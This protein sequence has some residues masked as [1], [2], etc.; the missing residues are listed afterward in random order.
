MTAFI[1][2]DLYNL[3]EYLPKSYSPEECSELVG[4]SANETSHSTSVEESREILGILRHRAGSQKFMTVPEEDESQGGGSGGSSGD[5]AGREEG[6]REGR[7]GPLDWSEFLQ[8]VTDSDTNDTTDTKTDTTTNSANTCSPSSSNASSPKF[9]KKIVKS[10]GGEGGRGSNGDWEEHRKL[11]GGSGARTEDETEESMDLLEFLSKPRSNPEISTQSRYL[12]GDSDRDRTRSKTSSEKESKIITGLRPSRSGSDSGRRNTTSGSGKKSV[13]EKNYFVPPRTI[14][15]DSPGRP[16]EEDR[17][18]E[19]ESLDFLEFLLKE[20][21]RENSKDLK[22]SGKKNKPCTHRISGGSP[23]QNFSDDEDQ[24]HPQREE[25]E[26]P[27]KHVLRLPK[28]IKTQTSIFETG[29]LSARSRSGSITSKNSEDSLVQIPKRGERKKSREKSAD[30]HHKDRK[31]KI[32]PG[33]DAE[34][35]SPV[36]REKE[37]GKEKEK[38]KDKE[39]EKRR[40]KDKEKRGREKRVPDLANSS[41]VLGASLPESTPRRSKRPSASSDPPEPLS[42]ILSHTK[43]SSSEDPPRNPSEPTLR[44]SKRISADFN[45]STPETPRKIKRSNSNTKP[46]DMVPPSSSRTSIFRTGEPPSTQTKPP[47]PFKYPLPSLD[48]TS[49]SST[50]TMASTSTTSIP[51]TASDSGTDAVSTRGTPPN[52]TRIGTPPNTA[53]TGTGRTGT[54]PNTGRTGTP[55]NSARTGTPPNSGRTGTPPNTG[56]VGTPPNTGRAGTPPK[57]VTPTRRT[58]APVS[59]TPSIVITEM[60]DGEELESKQLEDPRECSPVCLLNLARLQ[61]FGTY[62]SRLYQI[63]KMHYKFTRVD[64]IQRFLKN[65]L[66]LPEAELE[67]VSKAIQSNM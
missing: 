53:R 10:H 44:Q 26:E 22:I 48:P 7:E 19:S 33:Q 32:D 46:V 17:E 3:G 20:P 64:I 8:T 2:K 41:E 54:P 1:M 38:R 49:T 43:R 34:G 5:E 12:S 30:Q 66:I 52:T 24:E 59:P 21:P 27:K 47:S 23:A 25:E 28:M 61:A 29:M 58:G 55:P 67:R 16:V 36:G 63:Q 56:R 50:T 9:F 18:T 40:E 31:E 11:E 65:L 51:L 37:K 15:G 62:L 57:S 14:A 35:A 6:E 60:E 45:K 42:R 39:K 13:S 4:K